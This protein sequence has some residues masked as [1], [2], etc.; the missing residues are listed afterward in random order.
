[1]AS[2]IPRILLGAVAPLKWLYPKEGIAKGE[3]ALAS[4]ARTDTEQYSTNHGS[5]HLSDEHVAIHGVGREGYDEGLLHHAERMAMKTSWWSTVQS[6][7][8][9]LAVAGVLSLA[10]NAPSPA[11]DISYV[12]DNL[13]RLLAVI[14]PASDTAV[15]AYD[16]VGNLTG[17]TRQASSTL[18][19]FQFTPSGGPVGTSVTIYGTGFSATPASNT[20]KFNGTTATVATASTTVLTTT[21]PAGATNGTI[22]VT[23]A[24]VTATSS[25]SFTVGTGGAPTLSSFSPA[26]AG[27]GA[28]VT[29]TGT[30]YDTT[31]INDRVAFAAAIGAIATASS[32]SMTVPVPGSA[33]TGPITVSTT[34][35][36]ATSAQEF[37]VS[38]PGVT[39]ADIQYMGRIIVNGSTVAASITTANKNGLMVF[40]GVAGQRVTLGLS[41]VTVTQFYATVYRPD[42]VAMTTPALY[43]TGGGSIDLPLLPMTGTYTIFLDPYSTY[44]GSITVTAS[45]EL[46]GTVTPG[47]AGVPIS[48]TRVGQNA[49]YTF[50]GTAGQTVSL[51]LSSVTM[52]SG[53]V[54]IV[55]PDGTDLV[56]PTSFGTGGVVLDTQILPT[57]GTYAVF[58]NPA[59][60]Y[61]GN[62]TLTVYNTADV[63]GT[64]TI[65]GAAVTTPALTVP[66]RRARYTFTG[67]AGQRVNLGLSSVTITSSTVS[68]LKPDGTTLVST[69]IGTGGGSLDPTT[70]LPTTGTYTIVVDP[71]STYTGSMTLTLSAALSGSI[72]LD[73]AAAPL[74]LT[75]I[76]QTARYTFS[77]TSGQWVSL[78]LTSVTLTNVTVTLLKPDGTTLASTNVGTGGGG[79]EP[80]S[81]LP[82]TGTYTLVVDPSGIYTGNITLTL[83]SYLTGTLNLDGTATTASIATVGQNALYTFSGTAG[84][85]VSVGFTAVTI[86]FANVT[87]YKPDG[88]YLTA[89]SVGTA[90]GYLDL[91]AALPTTGTYTLAV[92]PSGA[93]TGTMTIT[94]SSEVTGSVTINAA[95]TA[96]TISRTGQ[97]ARYTFA[98]T[99][100]QQVTVRIT[101]NTLGSTTVYL[102]TP[103]GSYQTGAS[104]AG[105]SFN[106]PTVTLGTTGTYTITLNPSTT[107][108]GGLNLQVTNP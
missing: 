92:N 3:T 91:S 40:D 26:V 36:K 42:G 73:G 70:T 105:A 22:S 25:A 39:A 88:T 103:S 9:T 27:Y 11:A 95:A 13:G 90:G 1:M 47:G 64:I 86:P 85:W 75:R 72:T 8:R 10:M 87:L 74:S 94:L 81:T 57:T 51:Q 79:L 15:Y 106:L 41:A 68:M 18:A 48:I 97:N 67:T 7:L 2:R 108:T 43:N 24:G 104:G 65:D 76:G 63:T 6:S 55:K 20:V 69:A 37:F 33:Q 45:T 31:V 46:T 66:G 16:A 101:G 102:Y 107:A 89:T 38:P 56:A 59:S 84:Q 53:V 28:T 44:T 96:I 50:T 19:I 93:Y 21:V 32:T 30:N 23:V 71:G 61:T 83:M 5:K 14:D 100:S 52:S 78:G 17:I 4:C 98:G 54:S 60:T 35:G 58:V 49:R 99:A 62:A 34:Q 77:G 80:S 29:L 82:T 12:Y